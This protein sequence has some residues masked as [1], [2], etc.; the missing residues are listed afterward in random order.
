MARADK[1][2]RP[3]YV[4]NHRKF[5]RLVRIYQ[6]FAQTSESEELRELMFTRVEDAFAEWKSSELAPRSTDEVV[7][8]TPAPKAA[9]RR[10]AKAPAKRAAAKARRTSANG[11][12][13]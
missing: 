6:Q 11:R 2:I 1:V 12:M 9:P 7:A 4:E 8:E 10:A 5:M 3:Q 13:A